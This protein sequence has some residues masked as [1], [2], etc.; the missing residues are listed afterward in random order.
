[1]LLIASSTFEISASASSFA[2]GNL[3]EVCDSACLK[4]RDSPAGNYKM[5]EPYGSRG[6]IRDGPR[7]TYS[8]Y[9]INLV[10]E[11]RNIY[12]KATPTTPVITGIEPSQPIA[13]AGK[14][15]L[16]IVGNGFAPNS[17]VTLSVDSNIYPIP[18]ERTWFI[19]QN[20]IE[21]L[22]GLPKPG[23]TWKIW[24]TNPDNVQ[25][26][27]YTFQ[28]RDASIEDGKKVAALAL[29]YWNVENAI[30]MVAIAFAESR[31]NPNVGGDFG[32]SDF[33]CGGYASWGLWQIYMAVH[34]SELQKLGAPIDDPYK[35]A[36]WL[37]DPSNN[38]KV[39]YEVW[40]NEGFYAWSTYKNGSYKKFIDLATK[41]VKEIVGIDSPPSCSIYLLNKTTFS[42]ISQVAVN[43]TFYIYVIASDDF[44]IT[45]V[46]FSSDD[47][48]DGNP[49]GSW[50]EWLSWNTSSSHRTGYW[51]AENKR[52]EWT[53][54]TTG[55][56]EVW[57]EVKDT[58]GQ[59]KLAKANIYCYSPIS[60]GVKEIPSTPLGL[61]F[62]VLIVAVVIIIVIGI[63]AALYARKSKPRAGGFEQKPLR[64]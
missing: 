34:K 29:Q 14:Q 41:A 6:I 64:T 58:S 17:K 1:V 47:S 31:W 49:T 35:T 3:V 7:T 50:T 43:E 22:V 62:P 23:E 26:N 51:D 2:I 57:V 27:V 59:T 40:K 25:S 48:Q 8:S 52:K 28:V 44:G 33:N 11:W 24:V 18:P 46:R 54:T 4:V 55:D 42:Q 32:I 60:T 20:R 5:T 37:C 61:P 36:K 12:P 21:I 15:F 56:K 10:N 19:N 16:T 45:Q 63:G 53:F 13:C 30:T 9:I 38:V 39:A